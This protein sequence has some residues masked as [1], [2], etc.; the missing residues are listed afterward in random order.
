MNT[1]P[2]IPHRK[3]PLG[4]TLT[5]PCAVMT[6]V[7]FFLPWHHTIGRMDFGEPKLLFT[8]TGLD[9]AR[10]FNMLAR[11]A[12]THIGYEQLG[13]GKR[14]PISPL[15]VGRVAVNADIDGARPWLWIV[16]AL[17]AVLL[18]GAIA[19][20]AARRGWAVTAGLMVVAAGLAAVIA[21]E[22]G[23]LGAPADVSP[24]PAA[25]MFVVDCQRQLPLYMALG[26]AVL[27]ILCN[28]FDMIYRH[29]STLPEGTASGV[30][31]WTSEAVPRPERG[32]ARMSTE[33]HASQSLTS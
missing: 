31:P 12:N 22:A 5:I 2:D 14:R 27:A 16:P 19:R 6:F 28:L 17:A 32:Q 26:T 25:G 30:P 7:L 24:V 33:G 29:G 18:M 9:R 3:W 20:L 10:G 1:K 23:F 13:D 8:V 11:L 21:W 4:A 15:N